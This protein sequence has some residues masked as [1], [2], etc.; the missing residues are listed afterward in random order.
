MG[1]SFVNCSSHC[2]LTL[3]V[4][5]T[6]CFFIYIY[7]MDSISHLLQ[8]ISVLVFSVPVWVKKVLREKNKIEKC[9]ERKKVNKIRVW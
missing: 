2:L 9:E 3:Q 1:D 4:L 7:I 5:F 6:I 8:V